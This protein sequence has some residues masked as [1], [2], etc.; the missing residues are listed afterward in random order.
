MADEPGVQRRLA[1]I[2]A[3]DVVGY[4]RLMEGDEAG[5]HA[6]L[7]AV[8]KE[9]IEPRIAERHGRIVKLTGDGALVEFPSVVE[10]VLCAVDVQR[11]VAERNADVPQNQRIEFRIGVNL[12]DVIIDE[13]DIY[14]DGVNVAARLQ[15]LAEPG[16]I[17]VSRTVYN[18]VKNKVEFAFE[19]MGEHRVKNIAEP[20]TVYRVLPGLGARPKRRPA[21]IL[22]AL[23]VYRPAAIA[24]AV[25]I[26]L[27]AGVAGA[28][29]MFR[30]PVEPGA[31]GKA[32]IAVLPFDN[33]S[34]DEA[35]GRLADGITEDIITDL[36]RFRD[37]DVI[38][39]NSTIVYKGKPTDVRE[40]G[41][42]LNVGYVLEGS[43]QH[44]DERLRVTA[45][46]VDGRTGAHVWSERWDRPAA[47]FFAVQ[48][49]IAERV[50]ASLGGG[51]SYAAIT[52]SETQRVKRRAPASLSAYEHYLLSAEAKAQGSE[53]LVRTGLEHAEK[54]IALDPNLARAY[55]VR[56]WLHYFTISFDEDYATAFAKAGA[57]FRRAVELDPLDAE[58]RVALA[59]WLMETG[60]FVQAVA[61]ARMALATSPSHIHVLV[62]AAS[63]LASAGEVEEALSA[64]DRAVRLD[65]EMPPG[66]L[67]GVKDAFFFARDFERTI[68]AVRR[69]PEDS[70][71]L[72]SVFML[73]ASYAFLGRPEAE[74]ARDAFVAKYGNASAE[75]W[76]NQGWVFARKQEQDLFIESFRKLRL[77]VCATE[78]QLAKFP[79]PKRLPECEA[80]R[81]KS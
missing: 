45:Q 61:E 17:C 28:W 16:G 25:V 30:S 65:P 15:T 69:M 31:T 6:R 23:R 59:Y 46:L 43:I 67:R 66:L 37:L 78:A 40:I 5:T 41:R 3:A 10:A 71:S 52:A 34:G 33:L 80:Q 60:D 68:D 35:T 64:A 81:V 4:S 55:T 58:A 26:L 21:A 7:R 56:G 73:A 48:S 44:Q 47:D 12:G 20:I 51:L 19:P 32:S 75:L 62:A 74:E 2:L 72:G 24:A 38:A 79:D 9:L 42:A 29:Y 70:R 22:W 57:D 11:I 54:A 63:L 53:A 39:R 76:R 50:A 1:A 8:R 77:P 36:A 13:N 14:G 18:H 49:E 27:G